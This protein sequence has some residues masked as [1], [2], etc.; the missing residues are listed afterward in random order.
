M[1]D[2]NKKKKSK[3][4]IIKALVIFLVVMGILTFFSNT[5]MNMT[6]TQV[7]TQQIYGATLSNITRAS[8]LCHSNVE[9][10]V[11]A[12]NDMK[13][14]T[15]DVYLYQT[16]EAGD[17]LAHLE[18][19]E[20]NEELKTAK[21]E[22]EKME[23]KLGYDARKPAESNDFY[24]LEMDVKD[25]KKKVETTKKT[26]E[27]AKN[28]DSLVDQV[29]SDIKSINSQIKDIENSKTELGTKLEAAQMRKESAQENLGPS[30]K[31]YED[32][33]AYLDSVTPDLESA[34]GTLSEKQAE[35]DA[36]VTDP[37]DPSFDQ[38]KLDACQA[39]VTAAQSAVD[40]AQKK[41]DDA[42]SAADSA[43]EIYDQAQSEYDNACSEIDSINS[44]L[45]EKDNALSEKQAELAEKQKLQGE[46]DLLPTV[47][48]A[49]RAVKDAEHAVTVAEKTLNDARVNAGISSD[50]AQDAKQEELEKLEEQREKVKK[51]EEQYGVTEI[52]API[53][54]SVIAVN[55]TRGGVATK[56]DVLFVIADME[57]GFY[58]ECTVSKKDTEGMFIGSEVNADYCDYAT[59]ESIRPDPMDPMNSCILR[60]SLSAY[61]IQPGATTVNCTIS[62]SNRSYDCVVPKGAVHQ[63]TEGDFIYILVTKNSPLGER[64]I[65]RKV[66]VKVLASDSTSS[67]IEGAGINYAY[68]IVRT[69]KEIKNGEQVRLAQGETN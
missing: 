8:G 66:P 52:V 4:W 62:T 7:S 38:A 35:L 50:Q 1:S 15:V 16:V 39:E 33:A 25:A 55:A 51:L 12:E 42:Q 56:G 54:G 32:A 2:E 14:D 47:E 69:E 63:D 40:E 48:D 68:C 19:P 28:K 41:V 23:K 61:Y 67:A 64:Y 44:Q 6:L 27:Q 21:D 65:A 24:T 45:E 30:K 10:E 57:S 58:V 11:K 9:K 31:A 36:C 37:S 46:Y 22:L 20:N 29:K 13:I 49:E 3:K 43:K 53:S 60:I 34:Q 26:L 18:I 17:V 59:V 5:I